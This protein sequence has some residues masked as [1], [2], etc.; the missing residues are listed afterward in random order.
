MGEQRASPRGMQNEPT[1][2]D[3]YDDIFITQILA[4]THAQT[5][6]ISHACWPRGG[7]EA[8]TEIKAMSGTQTKTF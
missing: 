7:Y 3:E 1:S 8:G 4:H 2:S 6:S 5:S